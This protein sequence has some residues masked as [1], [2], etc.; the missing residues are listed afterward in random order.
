MNIVLF[1]D[2]I[3]QSDNKVNINPI[4]KK[5]KDKSNKFM[6]VNYNKKKIKEKNVQMDR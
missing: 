6:D 2:L 3:I 5:L 1:F 4:I